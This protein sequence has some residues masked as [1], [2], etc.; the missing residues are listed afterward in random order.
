MIIGLLLAATESRMTWSTTV[1]STE[2]EK[3]TSTTTT[4][5]YGL[6]SSRMSF[7][8]FWLLKMGSETRPAWQSDRKQ[9][10]IRCEPFTA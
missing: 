7:A 10:Q 5:I 4:A 8:G 6:L 2:Q 3:M 9:S 1:T